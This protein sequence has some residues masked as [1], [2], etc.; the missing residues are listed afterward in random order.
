M[1]DG[2]QHTYKVIGETHMAS[3]WFFHT[4]RLDI[5]VVQG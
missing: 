2:M 4:Q 3:I 1:F 5:S